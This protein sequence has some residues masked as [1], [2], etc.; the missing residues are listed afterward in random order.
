MRDKKRIIE[1]L[2]QGRYS[3]V[4]ENKGVIYTF[5]QRGVKDLFTILKE[6][7][8]IMAGA[9]IAD[10]VIGKGAAALMILGG[11]EDIYADI[12]S[13]NAIKL[14][15]DCKIMHS[16]AKSVSHIINRAG[17]GVCPIETLCNTVST[18]EECLPLIKNFLN[19]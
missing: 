18:P 4:I 10:K 6:R 13:N 16:F 14:L 1:I 15:Q 2:H 8:E 9:F 17:D 7:P 12:I 3:C 11:V 5:T 19:R